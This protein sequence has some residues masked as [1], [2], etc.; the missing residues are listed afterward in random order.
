MTCDSVSGLIPLYFYGEL[1]PDEEERVEQ[2]LHSCAECAR[3]MEQQRKLGAALDGRKAQVPPMLLEEC[4]SDLMAAVQ[5]G[6]PRSDR[7]A[8]GPWTL[9]L[10]AMGASFGGL[11]RLRQPVGALALVAIGFFAARFSLTTPGAVSVTPSPSDEVYSTDT[12]GNPA[13]K[14]SVAPDIA[15]ILLREFPSS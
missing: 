7:L 14:A 5:G 2:H 11:G 12:L 3:L 6:A 15:Q 13:E 4:R 1:P 8:K 9:F 10:E